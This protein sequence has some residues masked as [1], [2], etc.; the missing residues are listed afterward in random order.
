LIVL[1]ITT[2]PISTV[3]RKGGTHRLGARTIA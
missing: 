2:S 3:S 1:T